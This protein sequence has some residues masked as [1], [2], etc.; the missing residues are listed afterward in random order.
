MGFVLALLSSSFVFAAGLSGGNEFTA[1]YLSGETLVTCNSGHGHQM[2]RYRCST[3]VLD[4]YEWDYFVAGKAIDADSVTLTNKVRGKEYSQTKDYSPE[5]GRSAKHFN[6]WIS[7]LFQRPLL[8]YGANDI[9]YTLKKDD[10][11]VEAG[12]FTVN[13]KEGERSC[14]PGQMHLFNGCPVS[15]NEVCDKYFAD[16]NY[17]QY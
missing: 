10:A 4:P 3:E 7:T 5:K 11:I 12:R 15:A 17:C 8:G 16:E 1:T 13:V 14:R 2:I 9:G 6:L